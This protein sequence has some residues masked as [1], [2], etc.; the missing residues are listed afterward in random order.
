[1]SF[2][3]Y[4]ESHAMARAELP[5][6]HTTEYFR[7]NSIQATHALKADHCRIFDEPL[8]YFFYGRPAYR[9]PSQTEPTR[10]IGFY[11]ICL[12]FRPGSIQSARRLYPFDSGASQLGLYEPAIDRVKALKAFELAGE[13]EDARRISNCF[14]ESDEEYLSNKPR[15]DLR[16][17]GGEE[18]AASYYFLINGGGDPACDDRCSAIEVQTGADQDLRKD[19]MAIVLPNCFLEDDALASTIVDTWKAVPLAYDADIG[20]RPLEFHGAIRHLIRRFYRELRLL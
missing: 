17:A 5:L 4:V 12:V 20:M 7:L 16:F 2:S 9:D 6:V 3:E 14:F 13:V 15:R 19:V 11:P 18:D 1:M 10:E 8:L